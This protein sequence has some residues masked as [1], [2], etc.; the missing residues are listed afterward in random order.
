MAYLHLDNL[1]VVAHT[2]AHPSAA[3]WT[4]YVNVLD[5]VGRAHGSLSIIVL[6]GEGAPNAAQRAELTEVARRIPM[7]CAVITESSVVQG[8]VRV[9]SMI[10]VITMRGFSMKEMLDAIK[11]TGHPIELGFWINRQ[12][13]QMRTALSER[14]LTSGA[15]PSV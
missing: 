2:D 9:F 4:A 12:I 7:K 15:M 5:A 14:A 8:L 13:A 6:T 3:E 10:G 1:F 11:F